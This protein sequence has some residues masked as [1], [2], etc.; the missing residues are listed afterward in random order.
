MEK[1]L[2]SRFA[3]Q[4]ISQQFIIDL[5]LHLH[6]V[7]KQSHLLQEIFRKELTVRIQFI[8]S[9]E[10]SNCVI[11]L[12]QQLSDPNQLPKLSKIFSKVLLDEEKAFEENSIE[13]F[14]TWTSWTTYFGLLNSE[15]IDQILSKNAKSFLETASSILDTFV[16][17]IHEI[18]ISARNLSKIHENIEYFSS[19]CQIVQSN[20]SSKLNHERLQ[21]CFKIN[22]WIVKQQELLTMFK[23]LLERLQNIYRKD[24]DE[25]LATDLRSDPLNTICQLQNKELSFRYFPKINEIIEFPKFQPMCHV[26]DLISQSRITTKLFDDLSIKYGSLM[27]NSFDI[28]IFYQNIWVP[29]MNHSTELFLELADQTVLISTVCEYFAC[30]D[31]DNTVI[32]ELNLLQSVVRYNGGG[33]QVDQDR[34]IFCVSKILQY[35]NL[36]QC[37][38]GANLIIQLKETFGIL[39]NFEIFENLKDIKH[40]YQHKQLS[41]VNS[42]VSK[43]A[44]YLSSLSTANLEVI[45]AIID[46]V[47]FIMWVRENLNDLNELKT[48]IDISLTTCGGNPVDIDRV[49]CLSS[50]CTNFAPL[51]FQINENTNYE[52]LIARCKQVIESVEIKKD[53]T[54]LLREVGDSVKFW[55]E[56]KQSHGSVEETTLMQLDSIVKSGVFCLKVVES[57]NL[58]DIVSLS[59]DRDN[60][61]KRIY[62]LDQLREFRSK[63][64]LVVSKSEQTS[65]YENSQLFTHKLDTIT[66]IATIV[67]RLVES[68]HKDCSNYEISSKFDEDKSVLEKQLSDIENLLTKW[69]SKL[70]EARNR[71]YYLNYYVISQIVTLQNGIDSFNTDM[72]VKELE[73]FFHLLRLLNPEVTHSDI[74]QALEES[75][76]DPL[77]SS[78]KRMNFGKALGEHAM[79]PLLQVMQFPEYIC[80]KPKQPSSQKRSVNEETEFPNSFGIT[81]KELAKEV[82]EVDDYPL[83]LVIK[84]IIELKM[85]GNCVL[86]ED[87]AEWCMEHEYDSSDDIVNDPVPTQK[88]IPLVPTQITPCFPKTDSPSPEKSSD[89]YQLGYFL[90]EIYRSCGHKMRAE[91]QLPYNMKSGTP[92]LVVI[93][94]HEMFSFVFSLYISDNDKLPLPY[95]HETLIC[96]PDTNLEEVEIF[97]RRAL[98]DPENN[99]KYIFCIFNVQDLK[100][101]VAVHAVSKFRSILQQHDKTGKEEHNLFKYKL[102][103]ICSEEKEKLSY[104]ASAFEVIVVEI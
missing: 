31:T 73:Q 72:G 56:M 25:L 55:E 28:E 80:G 53:L 102:V 60:G 75:Q 42:K 32:S 91:R 4:K 26:C 83:K 13:H 2:T 5:L 9:G 99:Y 61:E 90:E 14:I 89:F 17:E 48:F 81:E 59:V 18:S 15:D 88:S 84:G 45:Q 87:L 62:S 66:E 21:Q 3:D 27:K 43:V 24:I 6:N 20:D 82:S 23:G 8:R 76:K 7:D 78:V 79:Q 33:N 98:M 1:Q 69:K 46:R 12:S 101:E 68:G 35:F 30:T 96:T 97:W 22:N 104:I 44:E 93:P 95:Y 36:Q 64:M 63:V 65:S 70:A 16:E 86:K 37:S 100:Y 77:K 40:T 103:L 74:V 52:T 85:S 92:N 34:L 50:V 10:R 49:T 19:L 51:I 39:E 54:K 41:C 94:T 71:Y 57:L 58:S 38:D 11:Q 67:V 47:D 29:A